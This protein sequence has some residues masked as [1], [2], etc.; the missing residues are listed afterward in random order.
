MKKDR[1]VLPTSP[2]AVDPQFGESERHFRQMIDALPAAIYTT[3]A[4]GR[5]THFNPAAVKLSGRTPQIGTDEWCVSWKLY[6]PDGTPLPHDECPMAIALKQGRVN[7]GEEILVERP[8]G[9]RL[10]CT[11][12]PTPVRDASGKVIGGINMLLDITERKHAEQR[13][14]DSE[15][16]FTAFMEHLPGLAWIKDSDGRYVYANDAA[17]RAFQTQGA[18]LYG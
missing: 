3:D 5:L 10:W 7:H 13:L 6:R 15:Q 18:D 17:Q 8:D 4:D 1:A 11:P 12:F 14:R 2:A 9:T 16:R